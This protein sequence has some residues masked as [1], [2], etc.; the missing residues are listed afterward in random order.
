MAKDWSK[1]YK[2]YRGLWVAFD[3]DEQTVLGSGKTAKEAISQAKLK[4]SQT[5][6][7]TRM[8]SEIVSYVGLL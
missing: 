2:K 5:P 1:I 3:V 8:P 6:F 7:L 4:T